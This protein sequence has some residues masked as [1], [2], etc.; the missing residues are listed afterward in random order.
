MKSK[1]PDYHVYSNIK[2]KCFS[3]AILQ[4][5]FNFSMVMVYFVIDGHSLTVK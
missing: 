5:Y 1:T 4:K 3:I 2:L